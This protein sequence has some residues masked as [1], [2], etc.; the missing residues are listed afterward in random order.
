MLGSARSGLLAAA[1]LTSSAAT[2]AATGLVAPAEALVG[3]APGLRATTT[4]SAGVTVAPGVLTAVR[5]TIA[6]K[7]TVGRTLTARPG[8]WTPGTAFHYA[9]FADGRRIRHQTTAE[10]RLARA[11]KGKR[12]TVKVTGDKPGYTPV[13][14]TSARTRKVR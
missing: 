12:I 9:W 10:L 14:K 11:Q 3:F 13:S 5:P 6:G 2:T 4:Q 8:T 1:L 7:A